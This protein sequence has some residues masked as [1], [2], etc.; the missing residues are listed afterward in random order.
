M[1]TSCFSRL[2]LTKL[3]LAMQQ[4][5]PSTLTK[6]LWPFLICTHRSFPLLI[7]RMKQQNGRF[8]DCTCIR[9]L[10]RWPRYFL[11]CS[12]LLLTCFQQSSSSCMANLP[13]PLCS[14][15]V[16]SSWA[17]IETSPY[18]QSYVVL[19]LG[20]PGL[21]TDFCRVLVGGKTCPG[22]WPCPPSVAG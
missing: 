6:P 22:I 14:T 4:N 7:V 17:W 1:T 15:P 20:P 3:Y 9:R 5:E 19:R 21:L 10:Q 16:L 2:S 8:S 11:F 12:V 13:V 18:S